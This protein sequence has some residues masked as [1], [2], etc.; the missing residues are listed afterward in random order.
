MSNSN[1]IRRWMDEDC[2]REK[3]LQLSLV[4]NPRVG[5]FVSHDMLAILVLLAKRSTAY[6][7][8]PFEAAQGMKK[9]VEEA[10]SL[11][12]VTAHEY[13]ENAMADYHAH[14]E[15]FKNEEISRA[16]PTTLHS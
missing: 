13:I 15:A 1:E 9:I 12:D 5:A 8:Y 6:S 3:E 10:L 7:D 11:C 14:V 2:A 16:V 4:G